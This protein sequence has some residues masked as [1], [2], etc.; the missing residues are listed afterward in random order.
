MTPEKVLGGTGTDWVW[1]SWTPT[2]TNLSGGTVTNAIYTQIGKTVHF[3]LFYT[4]SGANVSGDVHFS[5]PVTPSDAFKTTL[6]PIGVASYESSG[7]TTIFGYISMLSDGNARAFTMSTSG[8]YLGGDVS[9][10]STV[11]FTWKNG[12]HIRATGT[13][14]AA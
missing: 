13:Y 2:F 6:L 4:L 8:S 7:V 5:L 1:Q 9:L 12:D 3:M 11:P 10:S 14:E